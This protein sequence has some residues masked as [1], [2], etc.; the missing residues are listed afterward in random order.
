M[1]YKYIYFWNNLEKG[2]FDGI[3][4]Y[5]IP[6][7]YPEE[8]K[9]VTFIGFNYANQVRDYTGRGVHFYLDDYQFERVWTKFERNVEMLAKFEAV[10]S[11]DWSMYRDWPMAVQRCTL[12]YGI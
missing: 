7:I 2:I 8:Y 12:T 11:P 6:E 3:G 9:P 1:P 5:R 10:L 4:K